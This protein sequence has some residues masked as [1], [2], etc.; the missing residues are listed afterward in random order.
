M[1]NRIVITELS[2]YI[3]SFRGSNRTTQY[4]EFRFNLRHQVRNDSKH[5]G[6]KVRGWGSE[7]PARVTNRR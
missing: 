5:D 7:N 3:V 1:G 6:L 4:L 2:G